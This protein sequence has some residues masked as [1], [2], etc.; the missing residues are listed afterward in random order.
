ME[1][2]KHSSYHPSISFADETV[3]SLNSRLFYD[4]KPNPYFEKIIT[5]GDMILLCTN[6]IAYGVGETQLNLCVT[7]IWP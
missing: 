5:P 3:M 2:L 1:S 4:C 7:V 6:F